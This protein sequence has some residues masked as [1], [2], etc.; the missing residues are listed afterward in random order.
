MLVIVVIGLM[1]SAIQFSV[2][3]NKVEENLQQQSS[4][5]L[6]SSILLLNM[7]C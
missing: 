6:A 2:I 3:G 5:F 1:V 7:G 4:R